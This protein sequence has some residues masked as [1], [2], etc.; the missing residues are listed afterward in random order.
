VRVAL[1]ACYVHANF[2]ID[3]VLNFLHDITALVLK[4]A[5]ISSSVE[6]LT[7]IHTGSEESVAQPVGAGK[8]QCCCSRVLFSFKT[9]KVQHHRVV[10]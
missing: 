5:A 1:R 7:E 8:R 10:T 4:E 9:V 6:W 2:A 3:D